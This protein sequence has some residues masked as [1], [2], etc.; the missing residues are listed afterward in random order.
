MLFICD[1]QKFKPILQSNAIIAGCT[2]GL[3]HRSRTKK[4]MHHE[5]RL[6]TEFHFEALQ[7]LREICASRITKNIFS[8]SR[9]S[10]NKM[11]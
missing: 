9:F 11:I 5:S 8:K 1:M 6:F 4:L 2:G 3:C 10:V 7:V